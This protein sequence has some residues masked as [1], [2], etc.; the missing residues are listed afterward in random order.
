LTI[1]GVDV[2]VRPTTQIP[3]VAFDGRPLPFADG[4]FDCVQFV[5]VLQPP[6]AERKARDHAP[7]RREQRSRPVA[8]RSDLALRQLLP[9]VV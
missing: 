3:V 2:F 1:E 9:I 4:A 8:F 7:V 6:K 5:D